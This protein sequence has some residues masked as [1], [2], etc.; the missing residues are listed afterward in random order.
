MNGIFIIVGQLNISHAANASQYH[1]NRTAEKAIFDLNQ[2][3]RC[4]DTD[5]LC[6]LISD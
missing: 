3:K 6:R 4:L 5:Q 1:N 2:F